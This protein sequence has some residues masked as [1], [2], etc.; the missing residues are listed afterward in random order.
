MWLTRLRR[1]DANQTTVDGRCK[2]SSIWLRLRL[3]DLGAGIL[4]KWATQRLE[5][6]PIEM[7]LL[8][9]MTPVLRL[10]L[11]VPITARHF[12]FPKSDASLSCFWPSHSRQACL[13]ISLLCIN[14]DESS[15]S[16]STTHIELR[17]ISDMGVAPNQHLVACR[18]EGM[19]SFKPRKRIPAFR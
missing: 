18:H 8:A 10:A 15:H 11:V 16:T 9:V 4:G 14:S 19:G 3:T 17:T 13:Q 2:L 1:V 6:E 5:Q 12:P 7:K